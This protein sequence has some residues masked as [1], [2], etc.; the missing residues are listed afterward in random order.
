MSQY[1]SVA[2]DDEDVKL[3]EAFAS[4]AQ[5]S[6]QNSNNYTSLQ[7]LKKFFE[8]QIEVESD[9]TSLLFGQDKKLIHCSAK[10]IDL[11][12][13]FFLKFGVQ[14]NGVPFNQIIT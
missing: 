13:N 7:E 10:V 9:H 4:Q 5:I 14:S 12:V 3:L 11:P 8:S 2:F 1:L 6:I